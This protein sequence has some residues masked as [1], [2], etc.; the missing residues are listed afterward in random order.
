MD[1]TS[2]VSAATNI[3]VVIKVSVFG[4]VV[5]LMRGLATQRTR[6]GGRLSLLVK[7][8]TLAQVLGEWA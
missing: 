7:I 6:R 1:L 5:G 8:I 3:I 4:L 2:G